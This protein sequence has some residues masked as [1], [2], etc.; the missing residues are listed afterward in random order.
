[1]LVARA[2]VRVGFRVRVEAIVRVRIRFRVRV[3]S[4]RLTLVLALGG[5]VASV[6]GKDVSCPIHQSHRM[7]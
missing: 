2:A 7:V 1:M 3:R 6:S 4:R 5:V